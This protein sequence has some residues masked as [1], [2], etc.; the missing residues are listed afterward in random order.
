MVNLTYCLQKLACQEIILSINGYAIKTALLFYFSQA[1]VLFTRLLLNNLPCIG[2]KKCTLC[3]QSPL[4][5]HLSLKISKGKHLPQ[6]ISK[7][8]TAANDCCQHAAPE[9]IAKPGGQNPG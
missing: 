9:L 2:V 3:P 8:Q 7:L 1:I 6:K 4:I 5:N